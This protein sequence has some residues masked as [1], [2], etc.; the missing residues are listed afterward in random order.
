[1]E[2]IAKICKQLLITEP[3]Y[4]YFLCGLNKIFD[5]SIETACV[6]VEGINT[7]LRINKD[8]WNTLN[9]SNKQFII[10]HELGHIC[11][12]H[13]AEL[14][15][16][17]S[18]CK[19]FTKLN[20]AMD[21]AV[22]GLMDPN[23]WINDS[24]ACMIFNKFPD[25]PRNK[26]T[27]FYIKFLDSL[28]DK[29]N[30]NSSSEDYKSMKDSLRKYDNTSSGEQQEIKRL[31]SSG[32]ELH[33]NWS[34]DFNQLS[35]EQ[36]ELIKTQIEYQLKKTAEASRGTWPAGLSEM[37]ENLLKPLP[38]I[39]DWKKEFKRILGTSFDINRKNTRRKES[40]RFEDAK[41]S[42]LK[43]KHNI[44]VGIDT[45][46]SIGNDDFK[47]F[48]SEIYHV[49]KA[50]SNVHV[51][52]CDTKITN[53]YDYKGIMP[54]Q[55]TGRG[56]TVLKPMYDYYEEHRKN[57]TLFIIFTDGYCDLPDKKLGN[58]L[59]IITKTGSHQEYPSKVIYIN[60][61]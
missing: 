8:Y 37:L 13:I 58:S 2:S 34:T 61:D 43:K 19:N 44:L 54:N 3:F 36:Q 57:Y 55:I 59:F 56:G 10:R 12:F 50:G 5:N 60:K 30:R 48:F 4:G 45:S 28:E 42:K 17:K 16:W 33:K 23:I 27:K 6:G 40:K 24:T 29:N 52:E 26:G 15:M 49:Y 14:D 25:L 39:Y 53:S 11:L 9:D 22:N 46:G 35:K 38:P 32:N 18:Y 31:I 51:I 41:G 47:D 7:C 21:M 1:M 20:I